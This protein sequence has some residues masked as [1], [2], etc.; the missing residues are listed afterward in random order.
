MKR[1]EFIILSGIGATS[2][3][4]LSAC[5]HPEE[6]LIPALIPDD[7]YVPGIDYWKAS[8]CGM[9]PAG[10]GI[11]VRTR[12][13]KANKIEGNPLH[14]VNRGALCAR[15]QAGLEVLYNPDRIKGPMKRI[16][17]RGEGKW[18]EISWDEA[19]KTLADKLREI[20][21]RQQP[22]SSLFI[23]T[24]TKSINALVGIRLMEAYGSQAAVV[25]PLFNEI[26][27]EGSYSDSYHSAPAFDL[28]NSTYLLSFG[29]RFLETW[30][31]P[32]MYSLEY[33]R[34][35]STI[36]K[37]RGK[38]VQV[39]PRMSL[40]AANA[41]EWLPAVPGT[42]GVVALAIAQVILREGL[43]KGTGLSYLASDL[44]EFSP[45]RTAQLTEIPSEKIV[46]LAREF[47]GA[48]RPLAIG[49]VPFYA[50]T[51]VNLLNTVV[52]NLNK[53]GGVLL[54]ERNYD[55]YGPLKIL[56][57]DGDYLRIAQ[58]NFP[59]ARKL[60]PY[61]VLMI[62]N[63]NPVFVTPRIREDILSIPFIA[64]FSAFID[65]TTELADLVLPDHSY[66]E[67]WDIQ[68]SYPTAGG[69]VVSLTQPVMS[70][71]FNT[72]QTADVLLAV[73]A[74]LG[75]NVAQ[76]LPYASAKEIAQK[77]ATDLAVNLSPD[78]A[79][80]PDAAWNALTERGIVQG[81]S[82]DEKKSI[83]D[84]KLALLSAHLKGVLGPTSDQPEYPLFGM[85]YE[86]SVFGDGS[87]ANL[88]SLQELPDP[89]TS[90]MW[91][92]WVEINPKTAASLGIRDGDLVEVTNEHG[93][94]Q[95]PAALY[96]G[97]RP[98][99]V[100]MPFG[101]GHSALGRYARSRGANP[102]AL[103]PPPRYGPPLE[104]TFRVKVSKV[105]GKA[106]LIR[107]GT[108]LQEQMEKRR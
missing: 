78:Y 45:E 68:S 18:E 77:G 34:F 69:M 108:D 4:L 95:A 13:H 94:V 49:G 87:A 85:I 65:E 71:Q 60:N 38:L 2:A 59:Q 33:G 56:V 75:G 93:S 48:E 40:T 58:T 29:A 62:H 30:H 12:E 1:R 6:R 50:M 15:G 103:I 39:E 17:E 10:C 14:P 26:R 86:R 37:T 27:T 104:T 102:A 57:T 92:S 43:N 81:A 32:V 19:I 107:F 63:F 7:E 28:A 96:P 20:D 51:A 44:E 47:A 73:A 89:L 79:S 55:Y 100:A 98:D 101:Q 88:P 90:V 105:D 67:S 24:D 16:G 99:V 36:G 3:S 35:R 31:S 53:K 9:C 64:S 22:D 80:D 91:G 41:D 70:P 42:E 84:V 76:A 72:R 61:R 54:S 74:E 83:D 21:P 52:D 82:G 11:I 97:I 106:E 8:T 25:W 23:T 46:R 66:L 5:G